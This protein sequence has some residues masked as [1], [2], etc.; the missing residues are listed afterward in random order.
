MIVTTV[1]IKVPRTNP[2]YGIITMSLLSKLIGEKLG[3]A[4][5]LGINIPIAK[6]IVDFDLANH[7]EPLV[8]S[9]QQLDAMP[10]HLVTDINGG[11]N[12]SGYLDKLY[13]M[14]CLIEK[15]IPIISCPCGRV[16]S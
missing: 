12:L 14:H 4:S 6:Q 11:F 7:I 15:I 13:E 8:S 5:Y 3:I 10:Q 1:P 9:V 2:N 16:D